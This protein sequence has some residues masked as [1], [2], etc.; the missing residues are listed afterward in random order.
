MLLIFF[1]HTQSRR[2]CFDVYVVYLEPVDLERGNRRHELEVTESDWIIPSLHLSIAG[3]KI[4][5]LNVTTNST[6]RMN[7][8]YNTTLFTAM[9]MVEVGSFQFCESTLSSTN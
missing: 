3:D 6:L 9:E 1:I 8:L 2:R 7:T 5:T 4:L